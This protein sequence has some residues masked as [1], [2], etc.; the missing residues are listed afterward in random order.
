MIDKN[1]IGEYR[2]MI[3]K[4]YNEN[5]LETTIYAY[6]DK[7]IVRIKNHTDDVIHLAFGINQNPTWTDFEAFLEDRCPPRTRANI[8]EILESLDLQYYDPI[9]ICKKTEGRTVED[10]SWMEIDM[11]ED[12]ER[13]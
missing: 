13:D 8:K 1:K 5:I 4:F 7:E 11:D 9:S 10:N 2:F 12:M 6:P 3:I